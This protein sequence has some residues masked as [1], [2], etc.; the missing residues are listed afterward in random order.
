MTLSLHNNVWSQHH[1]LFWCPWCFVWS[2][3]QAEHRW[4]PLSSLLWEEFPVFFLVME[5]QRRN[6]VNLHHVPQTGT[7]IISILN[8]V[9][10]FVLITNES[11]ISTSLPRKLSA[12]WVWC[13]ALEEQFPRLLLLQPGA[14]QLQQ[15]P[16]VLRYCGGSKWSCP[17]KAVEVKPQHNPP[18]FRVKYRRLTAPV[19]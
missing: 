14:S 5:K 6:N 9:M 3:A 4:C 17:F 19:W 11:F 13:N 8:T 10:V 12:V 16:S 1:A 7:F 15:P 2:R 18:P